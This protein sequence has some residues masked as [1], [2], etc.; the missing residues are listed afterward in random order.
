MSLTLSKQSVQSRL[1]INSWCPLEILCSCP[2]S[3]FSSRLF[4]RGQN[5]VFLLQGEKTF[6]LF[7]CLFLLLHARKH[8]TH[9]DLTQKGWLFFPW[10]LS[11]FW[12]AILFLP[13]LSPH[14]RRSQEKKNCEIPRSSGL[15]SQ[16]A[17]PSVFRLTKL[18][19]RGHLQ[20][21]FRLQK[22]HTHT[23]THTA[24]SV[25]SAV[26]FHSLGPSETVT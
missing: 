8:T 10:C 18:L 3:A 17:C 16:V 2:E 21:T 7:A 15:N 23:H 13:S 22:K 14:Q 1:T 12:I 9:S 19:P 24:R 26:L 5:S 11:S 6:F 25:G 4:T 20:L